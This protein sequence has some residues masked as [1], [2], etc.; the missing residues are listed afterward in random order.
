MT[1]HG[2]AARVRPL[3]ATFLLSLG[4]V[5]VADLAVL[6]AGAATPVEDF[7]QQNVDRGIAIL[8]DKT[9][10]DAERRKEVHTL[11][12]T[13]V[14]T[15]KIGLFALGAAR[16]KASPDDLAAYSD[17]FNAFLIAD[18]E[19]QLDGY[20]GQTLKVTGSVERAPGD[21][22]VTAVLID[23]ADP[24]DTSLQVVF[25]VL[26][27]NSKFAVVDA[28]IAGVWLGL[29]QRADFEGYLGQHGGSVPELTAHLKEMTAQLEA[30][31]TAASVH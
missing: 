16:D 12:T 25:R 19:S 5:T 14:D 21:E 30:P 15:K 27:D 24:G 4:V 7:V 29:A 1:R 3:I 6:P 23:P 8:K 10:S 20:G 9:L 18:Y 17:A 2:L 11:L 31:K 22:I 26:A 13:V 28:S